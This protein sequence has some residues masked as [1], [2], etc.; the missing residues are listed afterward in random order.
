M[1]LEDASWED[2]LR[3][4][5]PLEGDTFDG[6]GFDDDL[7]EEDDFNEESDF[8][9]FGE[10]FRDYLDGIVSSLRDVAEKENAILKTKNELTAKIRL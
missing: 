3:K 7:S 1:T 6:D 8:K 4:E 9:K 10:A 2:F 5:D